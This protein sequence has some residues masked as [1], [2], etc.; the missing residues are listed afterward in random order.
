MVV[1][2]IE[3]SLQGA[4]Q[5][6]K[7]AHEGGYATGLDVV[8]ERI[9]EALEALLNVTWGESMFPILDPDELE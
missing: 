9:D 1:F 4:L 5:A 3:N 2:N 7:E 8:A 6:A